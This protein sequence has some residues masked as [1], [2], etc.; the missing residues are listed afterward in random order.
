MPAPKHDKDARQD[1]EKNTNPP[2]Q[3]QE[4]KYPDNKTE[5]KD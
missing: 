1:K 4:K 2:M 3:K 5:K